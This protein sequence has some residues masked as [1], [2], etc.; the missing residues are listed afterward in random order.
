MNERR[1]WAA[2][3]VVGVATLI[4]AVL[5]MSLFPSE[6]ADPSGAFT[7]PI[8]AFEFAKTE[9]DLV[10]IFGDRDDPDRLTRLAQM[11]HGNRW[12]F[13]FMTLYTVFGCLFGWAVKRAGLKHGLMIMMAAGLA[14]LADAIET[15][16]LL[17]MS[18]ALKQGSDPASILA[19][20]PI[21][22][23][24]KFAGIGLVIIGAGSVLI[25]DI[26]R[27]IWTVAGCVA[28]LSGV[29]T[30]MVAFSAFSLISVLSHAIGLGWL[31]MLVFAFARY[32]DDPVAA[33]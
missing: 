25:N 21:P 4:V 10:A 26:R 31:I 9:E 28:Y 14:G 29:L 24:I 27:W 20:L 6:M 16:C 8:Y 12:D 5:I 15:S 33:N 3:C 17:L 32:K 1:L 19:L 13:L 7:V 30:M 23:V 18:D 22:V 2:S 11:D